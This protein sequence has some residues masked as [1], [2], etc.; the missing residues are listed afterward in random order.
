LKIN[1]YYYTFIHQNQ[2]KMKKILM[3]PI[4]LI[5]GC[6]KSNITPV[7]ENSPILGKWSFVTYRL[8]GSVQKTT[9]SDYMVF[10]VD[11]SG[12]RHIGVTN[13]PFSYNLNSENIGISDKITTGFNLEVTYTIKTIDNHN[14]DIIADDT[15]II[16]TK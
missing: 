8:Y 10:N 14:L 5:F 4:L 3:I 13:I 1:K 7:P 2:H 11:N 16:L 6:V 12:T 9:Q 15:E